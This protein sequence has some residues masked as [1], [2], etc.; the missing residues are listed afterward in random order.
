MRSETEL[1]DLLTNYIFYE[2]TVIYLHLGLG[3]TIGKHKLWSQ[4]ELGHNQT[5]GDGFLPT[6]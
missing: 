4:N 1:S 5:Y 3:Q 6:H 2:A